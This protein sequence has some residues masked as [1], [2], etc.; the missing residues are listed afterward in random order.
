MFQKGYTYVATIPRELHSELW[1]NNDDDFFTG[2]E[3]TVKA[4]KKRPKKMSSAVLQMATQRPAS[5]DITTEKI[6]SMCEKK[7]KID[8]AIREL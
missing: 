7:V 6:Q 4:G 5:K 3:P 1:V 2:W 8:A